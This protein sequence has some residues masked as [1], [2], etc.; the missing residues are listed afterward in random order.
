MDWQVHVYGRAAPPMADCC[1]SRGL[2]LQRFPWNATAVRAGLARNASY[3][4]RPDGYVALADLRQS[5][6]RLE[7]YLDTPGLRG[8]GD[9]IRNPS[10]Q[11]R[12]ASSPA[13]VL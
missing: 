13:D 11:P 4:V 5:R 12:R 9:T 7:R 2:P 8:F 3:L 1:A 6:E 10:C